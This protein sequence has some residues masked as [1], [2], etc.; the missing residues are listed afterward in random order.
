MTPGMTHF[1]TG[2][3]QKGS[4]FVTFWKKLWVRSG[5]RGNYVRTG[6]FVAYRNKPEL[7]TTKV[8]RLRWMASVHGRH[9]IVI[10][11]VRKIPLRIGPKLGESFVSQ[12]FRQRGE[13]SSGSDPLHRIFW[14]LDVTYPG[15]SCTGYE[16]LSVCQSGASHCDLSCS[17]HCD[18]CSDGKWDGPIECQLI[19]QPDLSI[20]STSRG[21]WSRWFLVEYDLS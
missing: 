13:C 10:Q 18:K 3:H 21:E 19:V 20:S 6:D 1:F 15:S 2:C 8:G 12:F 14:Q 4:P 5:D 16:I 7:Q 17:W 11:K 9:Y